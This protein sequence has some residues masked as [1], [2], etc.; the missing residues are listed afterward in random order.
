M[1]LTPPNSK[2]LNL[3]TSRGPLAT[4]SALASWVWHGIVSL[5]LGKA[6]S[7][8]PHHINKSHSAYIVNSKFPGS[9]V[10]SAPLSFP[11]Q[12]HTSLT[13]RE[14]S[15]LEQEQLVLLPTD[16]LLFSETSVQY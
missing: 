7:A 2:R 5:V 11:E 3:E 10:P 8:Q 9:P 15:S 13:A 12:L 4:S 6:T 1:T 14:L 16:G